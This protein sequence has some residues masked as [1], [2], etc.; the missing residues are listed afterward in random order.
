MSPLEHAARIRPTLD[1]GATSARAVATYQARRPRVLVL[2]SCRRP[3]FALAVA[4][5]RRRCPGAEVW[6]LAHADA[7]AA[8]REDGA[9][10]VLS[11]RGTRLEVLTLPLALLIVM[12]QQQF[13]LLV[14]PQM[15]ADR[16]A[17]ANLYRLAVLIGARETVVLPGS[18]PGE[19]YPPARLRRLAWR[20]TWISAPDVAVT[21]ALLLQAL[22]V[23]RRPRAQRPAGRR[24]ILH[25]IDA[26]GMGGAQ[27]QLAELVNAMPPGDTVD[28]LALNG[29]DEFSR[30]FLTRADVGVKALDVSLST[31][32]R[33]LAVTDHCR[34]GDYD[35]VHTWLFASNVAGCAGARRA[36]VPRIVASVRSFNPGHYPRQLRWWHRAADVLTS[37]IADVVTVNAAALVPDHARWARLPGERI[38]VVHNG[39]DPTNLPSAGPESRAWLRDLLALPAGSLVVGTVGRLSAEKDQATFVRMMQ[40]LRSAGREMTGVIVGDGPDLDA[41]RTLAADLSLFEPTLRWLGGRADARR[42]IAGLD[43]FVLSSRIEGFPNALLE[44]VMMGVPCVA[45]RVGGVPDVLGDDEG[46][47]DPGDARAAAAL[48]TRALA[49]DERVISR[50]IRAHRFFSAG[51]MTARWLDLYGH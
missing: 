13:D 42:V 40:E 38:E 28:V 48:V 8:V 27:V 25:V 34:A 39:V 2:R 23:R 19:A 4:E 15:T 43:V 22:C 35:L 37:R 16:A 24:R 1:A 9:D 7:N 18:E 6:A 50:R 17:S 46:Q 11:H 29:G 14:I 33:I 45:S 21:F 20:A 49:H 5:A 51:A 30:G 32:E 47:F 36:G 12:R 44:A 26:L 3:Q 31:A 41:L 10:S